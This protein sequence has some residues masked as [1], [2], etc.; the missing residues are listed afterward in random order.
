MLFI[1]ER[2]TSLD[3]FTYEQ[4]M[5]GKSN[6]TKKKQQNGLEWVNKMAI[7]LEIETYENC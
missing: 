6:H 4:A 7:K 1:E 5:K 2:C 3:A